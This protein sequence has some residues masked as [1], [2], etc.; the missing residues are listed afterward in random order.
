MQRARGEYEYTD[1]NEYLNDQVPANLAERNLGNTPYYGNQWATYLYGTDQWR[2][3]NNVTVSLGL[4]WERTT[5][6]ETGL[7]QNLNSLA[8]A[9]GVLVFNS[10]KTSSKNF[11]PRLGIAWSPGHSGATSI[12]AGFGMGYD[13]IYDNVGTTSYPPQLSPT[14][15]AGNDPVKYHAPFLANGAIGGHDVVVG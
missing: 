4:R 7:L 15:D 5:V 12:R 11:A 14:I 1:L 9:P 6:P 13:V 3:K 8:N 10:P 2:V